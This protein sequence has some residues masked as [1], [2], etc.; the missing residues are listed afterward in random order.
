[1]R[2]LAISGTDGP[3]P[4]VVINSAEYESQHASNASKIIL[5][6]LPFNKAAPIGW[7]LFCESSTFACQIAHVSELCLISVASPYR[8]ADE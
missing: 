4:E 2:V 1:M 3:A 8:N 6:R 5:T 7:D